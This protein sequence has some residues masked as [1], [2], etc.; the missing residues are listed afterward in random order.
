AEHWFARF[1]GAFVFFGRL[2]P[3]VRSFVSIPAGVLEYPLAPYAALSALASL[4]WCLAFGIAGY[5]L[6]AHWDSVRHA[7]RYADYAAVVAD[8]RRGVGERGAR[9]LVARAALVCAQVR[10]QGVE[11]GG[12]HR[13]RRLG[14]AGT[15]ADDV[16][17]GVERHGQGRSEYQRARRSERWAPH[18]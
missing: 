14:V 7:F 12:R 11:L 1:G 6:G 9:E 13:A 4:V 16:R 2:T 5:A 10:A 3:L 15:A 17:G 18:D 8:A